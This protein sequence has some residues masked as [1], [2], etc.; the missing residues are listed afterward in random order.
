MHTREE[1]HG[2]TEHRSRRRASNNATSCHPPGD[3]TERPRQ[4]SGRLT[5]HGPSTR[6]R[7]K[8]D[9][10][11][12]TPHSLSSSLGCRSIQP[13]EP[14]TAPPSRRT[15]PHNATRPRRVDTGPSLTEGTRSRQRGS[16][17][18]LLQPDD[19]RAGDPEVA[20]PV[21]RSG[22]DEPGGGRR[23]PEV[24]LYDADY[25]GSALRGTERTAPLRHPS[26]ALRRTDAREVRLIVK[27]PSDRRSPGRNPG[28]QSAFKVSMINVSC[29]SH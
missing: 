7:P 16:H 6:Q 20:G 8:S 15:G 25:S 14:N 26:R 10:G 28:P 12:S 18:S 11:Q 24:D 21:R 2:T 9:S 1:K 17:V 13:T 19:S 27:R 29:N 22:A 5:V 4:T 23:H 3:G